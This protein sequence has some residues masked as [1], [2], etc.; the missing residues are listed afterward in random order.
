LRK[1]LKREAVK[2]QPSKDALKKI[3]KKIQQ[4]GQK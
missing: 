3:Q 4:K 2:V 1:A